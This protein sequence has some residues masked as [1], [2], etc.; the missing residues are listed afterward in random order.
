MVTFE[1]FVRPTLLKMA[2]HDA[3]YRP[4]LRARLAE[5]LSKSAGRLHLVRVKLERKGGEIFAKK[6]GNQSS[7]VLTSMTLAQGLLIFPA[8][9]ERMDAGEEAEVQV[10]DPTF[11]TAP[12]SGL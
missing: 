1:Q 8:D 12:T 2:G 10:L 5:P 6:T 9:A 11:L 4:R 7:G 3:L